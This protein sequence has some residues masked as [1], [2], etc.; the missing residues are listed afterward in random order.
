MMNWMMR[1]KMNKYVFLTLLG[2]LFVGCDNLDTSYKMD[3]A[4]PA[5]EKNTACTVEFAKTCWVETVQKITSCLGENREGIF[6]FDK[7]FCTNDQQMLIDFNDPIAMFQRPFDVFST[8][9]DFRV[10]SD[11][12]DECFRIEGT[13]S[14]F[15][16]TLAQSGQK[17]IF[18]NDGQKMS[19]NCL[20]GQEI[21]VDTK[22]V[23]GC[24]DK[25][26]A[27]SVPGI[28]L[29]LWKDNKAD[30]GWQL[31]LRGAGL[32]PIFRCRF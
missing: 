29:D 9:I 27:D 30:M 4:P 21:S 26:G 22:N 28:S 31:D 18:Q 13:R 25:L 12:K 10:L 2:F 32:E 6:S 19:F 1:H 11:S 5:I 8:P 14:N 7:K 17:V 3:K 16:I 15:T 20:D 24:T 23:E